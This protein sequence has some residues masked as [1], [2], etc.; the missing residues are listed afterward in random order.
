[1]SFEISGDV[2]GDQPAN[3]DILVT[4][5]SSVSCA[6]ER[7]ASSKSGNPALMERLPRGGYFEVDIARLASSTNAMRG[8]SRTYSPRRL[9]DLP[10]PCISGTIIP[11]ARRCNTRCIKANL[12]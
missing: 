11:I 12:N 5:I 1:M 3:D 2:F 6:V 10:T 8:I 7:G 4:F 9:S